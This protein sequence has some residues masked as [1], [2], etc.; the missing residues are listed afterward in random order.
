MP[1]LRPVLSALLLLAAGALHAQ[2]RVVRRIGPDQGLLPS[3]VRSLEQDDDGLL[4]IGTTGGLYRYDGVEM[5]RSAVGGLPG[6]VTL[7]RRA[8]DGSLIAGQSAAERLSLFRV[9][10]SRAAPL[11]GPG[12]APLTGVLDA[13]FDRNGCLWVLG[14]DRVLRRGSTGGWREL[15]LPPMAGEQPTM[16]RPDIGS[17]VLLGTSASVWRFDPDGSLE[18]IAA[19]PYVADLL[20]LPDGHILV[21]AASGEVLEIGDGRSTVR[22]NPSTFGLPQTRA[23]G[24]AV[25][26]GVIWVSL[27][28]YLVRLDSAGAR[29]LG[30][31][32]GIEGGG[33]LLVDREGTLWLG[34]FTGLFQFPEPETLIWNDRHGLPSAHARFFSQAGDTLW[35]V[36]WQGLGF[37]RQTPAGWKAAAFP[38]PATSRRLVRDRRGTLWSGAGDSMVEIRGGHAIRHSVP[39]IL[40]GSA[41]APAGGHWL[42]LG[43]GVWYLDPAGIL[44]RTS[45]GPFG[46]MEPGPSAILRAG[47]QVWLAGGERV[48]HAPVG[49]S[50]LAPAADWACD[51]LPGSVAVQAFARMGN[52]SVWAATRRAGVWHHGE[53]GWTRLAQ[54]TALGALSMNSLVP[55]PLGGV[56][57]LGGGKVQRV[58]ATAGGGWKVLERISSWQ[59]APVVGAEDV[60][61]EPDSTLWLTTWE[62]VVRIPAGARFRPLRAPPVLLVDARADDEEIP[63]SG[64][65]SLPYQRNRLELRFAAPSY[66]DPARLRYQV[67]L[68]TRHAWHQVQGPPSFR[69]VGLAPGRYRAQVRASLDGEHWSETP[70]E[71]AFLVGAPWYHTTPA[72]ALFLLAAVGLSY[73]A[74]R[75]RLAFLVGLERQ[76]TAIAMDLHDQIGSG[77]G[78][79]GILSGVLADQPRDDEGRRIAME[80]GETASELGSSLSG[81]VWALD[82]RGSTLEELASRLAE[83]GSR[84][85]PDERVL[86]SVVFPSRWP[87]ARISLQVRRSVLLIGFEALY[88][89]ARHSG[90]SEVTLAL[91]PRG[92]TWELVVR[93][94]GRGL[95]PGPERRDGTGLRSMA[96]RAADLGADLALEPA[97]GGGTVVTLRFSA[98]RRSGVFRAAGL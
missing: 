60:Y 13:V 80:I 63:L 38:E 3:E 89:A 98:H 16:L 19:T 76:R 94:N 42:M 96:R 67:R 24:L 30:H 86:F 87:T 61:E 64:P 44:R 46:S 83:Q 18:H 71:F 90:A 11:A 21:L 31:T 56:W 6:V 91:L 25:R 74:Y 69:W 79:I 84:L 4:W 27:D 28:R 32:A 92:R 35:V 26:D 23:L 47:G 1:L 53:A 57:V 48:C 45:G 72:L 78:S 70:A 29:V 62:G 43:T 20:P 82:P 81:I 52:G 33:P 5:R 15:P 10:S 77:L 85:F 88:N 59:G 93:D 37:L 51:S 17:G 14:T 68:D 66:R 22:F 49:D 39:G 41:P 9:A 65:V 73:L 40:F 12:G 2:D 97:A 58:A 95:P 34:T 7:L 50:S 55:S 54:D 8:S 75:F 36:T